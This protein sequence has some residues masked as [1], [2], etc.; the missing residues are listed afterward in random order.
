[1]D[2]IAKRKMR[3][4]MQRATDEQFWHGM[5]IIHTQAYDLAIKHMTEAMA[6][7]PGITKKQQAAAVTKAD[8][9]R[10]QWDGL[11]SITIEDTELNVIY[12]KTN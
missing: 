12:G 11:E 3:Q 1:M 10:V 7:I 6:C 8:E 5:N 4:R 9:I 2:P